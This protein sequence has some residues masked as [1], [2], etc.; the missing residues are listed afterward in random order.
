MVDWQSAVNLLIA[1]HTLGLKLLKKCKLIASREF[2]DVLLN[3]MLT[4]VEKG[5]VDV[6][7]ERSTISVRLGVW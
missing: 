1:I 7:P 2:A 4:S 6:D 5:P 3:F